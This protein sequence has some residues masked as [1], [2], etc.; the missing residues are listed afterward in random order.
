MKTALQ[1][2]GAGEIQNNDTCCGDTSVLIKWIRQ[3]EVLSEL[4]LVLRDTYLKGEI[5]IM[6]P[7]LAAYELANVLRYNYPLREGY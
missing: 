2:S 5:W 7:S 6:E 3:G 1:T 4:A